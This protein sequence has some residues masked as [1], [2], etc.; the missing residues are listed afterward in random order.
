MWLSFVNAV[1]AKIPMPCRIAEVFGV[2]D[3]AREMPNANAK[4]ESKTS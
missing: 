4:L 2:E 1:A 3:S